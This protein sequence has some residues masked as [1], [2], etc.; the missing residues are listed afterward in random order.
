[1]VTKSRALL[2]SNNRLV[3]FDVDVSSTPHTNRPN[4]NF[5]NLRAAGYLANPISPSRT[6]DVPVER[7]GGADRNAIPSYEAR[8]D[9]AF[10]LSKFT[11]ALSTLASAVMSANS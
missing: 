7:G 4:A 5:P 6:P 9:S 10:S 8:S 2:S 11:S 1:M 3:A